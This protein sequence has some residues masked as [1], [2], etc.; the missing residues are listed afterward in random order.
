MGELEKQRSLQRE[1]E[2]RQREHE[3]ALEQLRQMKAE[4]QRKDLE[5]LQVRFSCAQVSVRDC[6]RLSL[7]VSLTL[8]HSSLCV[9]VRARVYLSLVVCIRWRDHL[10]E[11]E[12][13][14]FGESMKKLWS[15]SS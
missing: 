11:W 14:W 15:S 1:E 3:A 13:L 2:K 7:S 8:T 12:G 9:C 6:I 10:C 4:N 5:S